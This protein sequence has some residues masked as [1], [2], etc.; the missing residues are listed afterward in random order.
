MRNNSNCGVVLPRIAIIGSG[1]VA[2]HLVRAFKDMADVSMVDPHTLENMPESCDVA[3]IAVKDDAIATVASGIGG[4]AAITA[5]TSGSVPISVLSES[6]GGFGV[7]YPMQTFSKDSELDYSE[8]PF[9]IEG[10]DPDTEEILM[11]LAAAVSRKV[12]K[13]D[14]TTRR[15]LHLAAVFAC[16]FTNRLVGIA[17]EILSECGLDYTVMLPL[18][19]QTVSKLDSLRPEQAQTGPAARKDLK[20]I[21]AHLEMLSDKPGLQDLYRNL[22]SQIIDKSKPDPHPLNHQ[23]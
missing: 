1:N 19:R 16:N 3:L 23:T 15:R 4:R 5:H 10:S 7:F 17:D 9:F 14:S 18:L 2:T 8:I 22:S 20:V 6:S 13:A 11:N 12:E 21:D